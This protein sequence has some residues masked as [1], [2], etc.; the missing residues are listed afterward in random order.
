MIGGGVKH[1]KHS[2]GS[3]WSI[4]YC[5]CGKI[6]YKKNLKTNQIQIVTGGNSQSLRYS[7][8]G[9]PNNPSQFNYTCSDCNRG[10]LIVAV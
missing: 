6:L 8:I 1:I 10:S 5:E 4:N 7:Y 3:L 9:M 2:D